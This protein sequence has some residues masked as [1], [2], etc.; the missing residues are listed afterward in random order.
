[1]DS[2]PAYWGREHSNSAR[3][4]TVPAERCQDK[5][6]TDRLLP[7]GPAERLLPE[8]GKGMDRATEPGRPRKAKPV[9][10]RRA[11]ASLGTR[12]DQRL[13]RGCT[14]RQKIPT[15]GCCSVELDRDRTEAAPAKRLAV[16]SVAYWV[17]ASARR[18]ADTA[19]SA[20]RWRRSREPEQDLCWER[21]P[22]HQSWGWCA[23]DYLGRIPNL[24]TESLKSRLPT[25]DKF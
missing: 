16:R 19:D 21:Q 18:F 17:A 25:S 5:P 14:R 8:L 2:S 7:L 22:N 12:S 6:T 9:G 23:A 13:A 10:L 15:S 3:Q 4:E 1:M 11:L 24:L 20:T